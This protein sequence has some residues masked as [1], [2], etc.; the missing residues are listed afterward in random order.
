MVKLEKGTYKMYGG[1][2]G[3][4]R[5][6]GII[7]RFYCIYVYAFLHDEVIKTNFH[8]LSQCGLHIIDVCAI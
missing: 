3:G 8:Y 6:E 7:T 4:K 5:S 2:R 1:K